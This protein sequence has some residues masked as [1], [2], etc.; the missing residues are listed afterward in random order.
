MPSPRSPLPVDVAV[1]GLQMSLGY[2]AMMWT[3]RMLAFAGMVLWYLAVEPYF[4]STVWAVG[5]YF[6]VWALYFTLLCAACGASARLL[7]DGRNLVDAYRHQ[8]PDK[9]VTVRLTGQ[10]FGDFFNPAFN[11]LPPTH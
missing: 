1:I 5:A 4:H 7:T 10:V 3:C 2:S 6:A 9:S 8:A 11:Q